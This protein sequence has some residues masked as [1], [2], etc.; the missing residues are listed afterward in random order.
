[1]QSAS[2]RCLRLCVSVLISSLFSAVPA[3]SPRPL[4]L[5]SALIGL[6]IYFCCYEHLQFSL[7]YQQSLQR[8]F[9]LALAGW[10]SVHALMASWTEAVS[11]IVLQTFG[12]RP[13]LLGTYGRASPSC[14][15]AQ[16]LSRYRH[17]AA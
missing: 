15:L 11:R 13:H 10:R 16:T 4:K 6:H 17:G 2:T 8:L 5:C 1:M 12:S 3:R 9:C 7:A 14:L